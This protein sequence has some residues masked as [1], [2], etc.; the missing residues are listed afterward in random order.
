MAQISTIWVVAAAM[1]DTEGRVL[2]QQR[3]AG[4]SLAGLWEFPGGK[5]DVGETPEI[6]LARELHEE[7]G[8]S[9]D[10]DDLEVATFVSAPLGQRHL[11]MLLYILRRWQGEPRA[12]EAPEIAWHVPDKLYTL[13]MP[14]ADVPLVSWL[15]H[16]FGES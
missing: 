13:A 1:L 14:P 16:H 12:L 7:L 2:V 15:A 11:V 4:K 8:I 5:I 3:P 10:P 6:A 9:V